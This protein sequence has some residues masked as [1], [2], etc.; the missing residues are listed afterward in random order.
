MSKM[1][2]DA[3]EA[4]DPFL[5]ETYQRIGGSSIYSGLKVEILSWMTSGGL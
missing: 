1:L 3:R 5:L 4:S 2:S